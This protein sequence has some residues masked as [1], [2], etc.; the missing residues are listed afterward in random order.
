MIFKSEKHENDVCD[1]AMALGI[2]D[3]EAAKNQ[4]YTYL[5]L[6]IKMV[7]ADRERNLVEFTFKGSNFV[8]YSGE[9]F[10]FIGENAY[11]QGAFSA[12]FL[13]KYIPFSGSYEGCCTR[14][15]N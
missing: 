2:K 14:R 3:I 12:A 5:G 1:L 15:R 11:S 10:A 9:V 6:G 13:K 7:K 4:A 8:I